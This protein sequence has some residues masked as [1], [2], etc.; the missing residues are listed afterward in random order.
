M[1]NE[2]FLSEYQI[3]NLYSLLLIGRGCPWDDLRYMKINLEQAAKDIK[4]KL[5][6]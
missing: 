2:L 1:N 3:N 4:K 6:V 5:M